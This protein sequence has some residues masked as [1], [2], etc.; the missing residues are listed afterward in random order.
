MYGSLPYHPGMRSRAEAARPSG[1][2]ARLDVR[3]E[4]ERAER[5]TAAAAVAHQ[6]VSAFMLD[7]AADRAEEVLDRSTATA[8][9]DEHFDRSL[10]RVGRAVRAQRGAAASRR[11]VSGF[12]PATFEPLG[13]DHAITHFSSGV[14]A[15]DEWLERSPGRQ[16]PNTSG[17]PTSGSPTT[18]QTRCWGTSPLHLARLVVAEAPWADR[19]GIADSIP[20]ILLARLALTHTLRGQGQGGRLLVEALHR[21]LDAVAL[22]GGRLIVVDAIDRDATSF[23]EH[24]GFTRLPEHQR[25]YRKV[26]DIARDL[27]CD[28]TTFTQTGA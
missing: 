10:G 8:L 7:A 20:A 24:Y 4:P 25:L 3:A 21:A 5:I 28:P 19:V 15:L 6:S 12:Q 14:V 11:S 16:R 22:A 18:R 27:G 2:T 17:G 13:D 26:T 23:Y 9:R 1:K